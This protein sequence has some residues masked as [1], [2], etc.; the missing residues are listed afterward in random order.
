MS[1]II[2]LFSLL[3][4]SLFSQR[5]E[6]FPFIGV[7]ISTHS[8]DIHNINYNNDEVIVGI[9]YGRQTVDWRTMF[10]YEFE[11]NGYKSFSLEID[12]ILMDEIYGMAEFR[13]YL[14]LS[15]GTISYADDTFLEESKKSQ[16][17]ITSRDTDD[18]P[19][20]ESSI[21]TSGYFYGINAG[22]IIYAAD[23]IDID[24][25]YHYYFVEDFDGLDNIQGGTIAV[26]Y[27]Y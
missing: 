8:V 25:S 19:E 24:V 16:P 22:L 26:H 27:F 21:D 1:R 5:I 9:R 2:I 10:T 12:K 18:D 13:P 15:A 4:T 17:N 7:T 23:N 6:E 14:G 20:E 11:Q 3:F